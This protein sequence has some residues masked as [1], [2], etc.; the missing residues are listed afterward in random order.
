MN[1]GFDFFISVAEFKLHIAA[2]NLYIEIE[3]Q[4]LGVGTVDLEFYCYGGNTTH[5]YHC[6]NYL[7]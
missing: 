4:N 6:F 2:E 1:V 5:S 3:W 7:L